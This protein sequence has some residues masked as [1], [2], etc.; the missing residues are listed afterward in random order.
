M[1]TLDKDGGVNGILPLI[2]LKESYMMK[3]VSAMLLAAMFI[4]CSE[5]AK[6][7]EAPAA[8]TEEVAPA[9]EATP[10]ADAATPAA[11]VPAADATAPAAEA[12]A[13]EAPAAK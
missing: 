3:I 2:F 4:G 10:A 7:E 6:T 5:S 12:P 8:A 9:A 1:K 13:A 11:E